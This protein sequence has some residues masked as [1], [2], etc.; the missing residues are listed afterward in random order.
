M[1][2]DPD[3]LPG[4]KRLDVPPKP[5]LGV[6]AA[7]QY[8]DNVRRFLGMLRCG[9]EICSHPTEVAVRCM[10]RPVVYVLRASVWQVLGRG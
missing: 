3:L 8:I 9:I 7:N 1:Q 6:H 4:K 10:L 2:Q 5:Y